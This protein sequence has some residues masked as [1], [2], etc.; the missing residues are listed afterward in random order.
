MT[1]KDK[2]RQIDALRERAGEAAPRPLSRPAAPSPAPP[3]LEA[4]LAGK[5]KTGPGGGFFYRVLDFPLDHLHGVV[6]VGDLLRRRV[7]LLPWVAKSR[8]LTPT[9]LGSLLFID[10]ETSGLSGGAG[11]F[12]FLVGVGYFHDGRFRVA[13]YFMHDV[14][15]EHPLL[16]ELNALIAQHD[17]LVSYNGKCFDIPVLDSRNVYHRLRSPFESRPHLDLLH[18]VRRIWR[19]DLPDCSLQTAEQALL[20]VRRRGDIPGHLIPHV[21]FSYLQT[22]NPKMLLPVFHHNQLDVL[23]MVGLLERL[24]AV[25][26]RPMEAGSGWG[27]VLA[28]ARVYEQ[29]GA[30]EQALALYED[31]RRRMGEARVP[32][33]LLFRMAQVHKRLER[34]A[35]A[36]TLWQVCVKDHP[37]HPLPYIELAKHYEHR[38]R[39]WARALQLV[40]QAR[41][42][43]HG[44]R[45]LARGNAWLAYW[46]D[47]ERRRA[48]L[49]R[50]LSAGPQRD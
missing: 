22:Q 34:G 21:Y 5:T 37:F 6:A 12:A 13:Q 44:L 38:Q 31:A 40:E 42:E 48:R 20:G 3:N 17:V 23:S 2:L 27:Q 8:D 15:E 32:R 11:T 30:W 10:T 45:E 41:R 9:S 24:L 16:Q 28:V 1:L 19:R 35:E 4:L 26:E 39:D 49:K 50:K 25:F 47:L 14:H 7:E 18:S 33:E 29:L 36:E 46:E 43:M